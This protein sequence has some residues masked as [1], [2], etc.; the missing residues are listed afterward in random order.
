MVIVA[1][2][3]SGVI[4]AEAPPRIQQIGLKNGLAVWPLA[5]H[6][7][8]ADCAMSSKGAVTVVLVGPQGFGE[9]QHS[10]T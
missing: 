9:R 2:L 6:H 8:S 3:F 4:V 10:S 1:Q 5:T 7:S